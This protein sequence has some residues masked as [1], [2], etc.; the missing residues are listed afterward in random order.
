M[1]QQF[2]YITFFLR[3]FEFVR[4]VSLLEDCKYFVRSIKH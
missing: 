1:N 2:M 3:D 4:L